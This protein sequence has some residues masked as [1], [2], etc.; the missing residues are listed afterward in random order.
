MAGRL[1][2][3]A[4][5]AAGKAP[6]IILQR[7]GSLV[8]LKPRRVHRRRFSTAP[9]DVAGP[10]PSREPLVDAAAEAAKTKAFENKMMKHLIWFVPLVSTLALVTLVRSNQV[11]KEYVESIAPGFIDY[12]RDQLG[13]DEEDLEE[14][15]RLNRLEKEFSLPVKVIIAKPGNGK[16]SL[17]MTVKGSMLTSDLMKQIR[18]DSPEFLTDDMTDAN[19]TFD[20][21]DDL[22]IRDDAAS[23]DKLQ[24]DDEES[25]QNIIERETEKILQGSAPVMRRQSDASMWL[26]NH[27][28]FKETEGKWRNMPRTAQEQKERIN[29]LLTVGM[30]NDK[31]DYFANDAKLCMKL[32]FS[33]PYQ[34]Y[35][36]YAIAGIREYCMKQRATPLS[37][38]QNYDVFKILQAQTNAVHGWYRTQ[39]EQK[40]S[41]GWGQ[42]N[43]MSKG[44]AMKRIEDLNLQLTI[45]QRDFDLG[46]K[47]YD[48][49]VE[50]IAATKAE[51]KS[52]QR[53]YINKFYFF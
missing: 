36:S 33:V 20:I 31:D 12:I 4:A 48:E 50:E 3:I 35:S 16:D 17:T 42:S 44:A 26:Y 53:Q 29:T 13:F 18:E 27:S 30:T 11:P 49:S 37:E 46:R 10:G 1:T 38:Y 19:I 6:Q 25:K 28:S 52:L 23:G 45:Q 8:Q 41:S 21:Q 22:K 14:D 7:S 5:C 47:G 43:G 32:A 34:N 24:Q 15:E 9:A 39:Q 40:S 2:Q 51:I